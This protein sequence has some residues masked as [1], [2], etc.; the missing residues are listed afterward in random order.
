MKCEQI[1]ELLSSYYD[2]ELDAG[3]NSDI[4]KHMSY[5]A[6]C[7]AELSYL[8]QLSKVVVGAQP[9]AADVDCWDRVAGALD[10][11]EAEG[12]TVPSRSNQQYAAVAAALVLAASLLALVGVRVFVGVDAKNNQTERIALQMPANA[13]SI[14]IDFQDIAKLFQRQPATALDVVATRLSG[15]DV[16]AAQA[17]EVL[18]YRPAVLAGLPDGSHLIAAKALKL[19]NCQCAEGKC[20]CGPKGCS[21]VACL[22]RRPD[23]SEFLVFEHCQSQAVSFGSL[24]TQI[25]KNDQR[26][27]Q[28]FG[29]PGAN[30]LA[31]SWV[32]GNRRLTAIGLNDRAE[33]EGIVSSMEKTVY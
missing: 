14:A 13:A 28:I 1:N 2:G 9:R 3:V 17:E 16:S 12:R 15:R 5:C 26:N 4:E 8:E 31:A 6:R 33:V 10:R 11:L 27:L 21:C 25:A 24:P 29:S 23:G 20:T 18:G 19:P 30:T 22:C 7:S 32:H